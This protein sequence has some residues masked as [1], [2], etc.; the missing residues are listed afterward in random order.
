MI[1]VKS[2]DF[3][4]SEPFVSKI[5]CGFGMPLTEESLTFLETLR[6]KYEAR[7]RSFGIFL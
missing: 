7:L 2:K 1:Y 4:M 6:I 5:E 3:I